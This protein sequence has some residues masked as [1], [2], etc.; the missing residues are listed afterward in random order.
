MKATFAAVLLLA[1]AAHLLVAACSNLGV[2][3]QHIFV[4]S[5]QPAGGAADSE[6]ASRG[7]LEPVS[8]TYFGVSLD[9]HKESIAA[10]NQR[11]GVP[12]AVYM[13]FLK[14][15]LERQGIEDLDHFI[16]QVRHQGGLAL[17]TL[18]PAVPLNDI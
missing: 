16:D 7:R 8:G 4:P 12:A 11:V 18:E 1:A 5:G 9:L 10:F 13:Q 15:P 3:T 17:L 14:F 2:V 6:N